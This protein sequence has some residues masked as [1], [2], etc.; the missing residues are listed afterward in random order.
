MGKRIFVLIVVLMSISLV[1]IISVQLYWINNAIESK[2]LQFDN[3]VK[4]AL[5]A[6]SERI[7]D[8]ELELVAQDIQPLMNLQRMANQAQIK[9]F[10]IQQID[11]T[12]KKPFFIWI[13]NLRRRL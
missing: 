13:N 4:I 9:S 5:A 2:D 3:D 1:G 6:V 12:S 7:S 10:L 11:T 8:R